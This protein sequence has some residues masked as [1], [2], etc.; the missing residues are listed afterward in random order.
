MLLET[1]MTSGLKLDDPAYPT[2]PQPEK[3]LRGT[4]RKLHDGL[5][6]KLQGEY[7]MALRGGRW[8]PKSVAQLTRELQ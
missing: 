1:L 8:E 5:G 2:D 7:G 3:D 4:A 6:R